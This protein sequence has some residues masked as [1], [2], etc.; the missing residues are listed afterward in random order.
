MTASGADARAR[1]R[2]A[3]QPTQVVRVLVAHATP[4]SGADALRRQL[5][6]ASRHFTLIDFSQFKALCA[7]PSKRLDRPAAMLTFDDGLSSNYQVGAAILEEFKTRG[8][9]FVVPGFS[10]LRDS[11]A[12]VIVAERLR[13]AVAF[14]DLPMSKAQIRELADRGHTIGNHTLMHPKLSEVPASEYN[15]EIAKSADMLDSWLNH[16]VEAFA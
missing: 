2:M 15:A 14:D 3:S 8:L 13:T 16:P 9:F 6:W 4:R 5:E 10:E 1:R 7:E 11:E 12:R